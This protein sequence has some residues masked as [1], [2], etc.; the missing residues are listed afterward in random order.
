MNI[1]IIVCSTVAVFSIVMSYNLFKSRIREPNIPTFTVGT[2]AGYAPF[3]SINAQGDY[4]GFDIDVANALAQKM[5]KQLIIKDLGSMTPLFIALEQRNI[6]AIIWGLSITQERLKKVA[7]IRYQ[8]EITT[9]YPL[10]FW[11]KIPVGIQSINS[12]NGMT[13]C[14]EPTSSQDA[15]L[16]RYPLINKKFTEKVDDA[17]FNIQYAKADAALVE[18]AIAKKF[19]KKYPEIVTLDIPLAPEDQV[20]G[21]GIALAPTDSSL[22]KEIQEALNELQRS[23]VIKSLEEKWGISE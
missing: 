7:M 20:Q 11:Q 9:S 6:D 8:G 2:A 16:S 18:P 19:K 15:V 13:I 12:M 10:I 23:G 22:A 17:L 4:E 5:N 14:V 1:K 21:V 3:V